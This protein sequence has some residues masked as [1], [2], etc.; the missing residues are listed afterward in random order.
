Q[1]VYRQEP[2]GDPK[3]IT[4]APPTPASLRHADGR[5]TPDGR[6][7]IC[8]RER[9]EQGREAINEIIA[10]PALPADGYSEPKIILS[11]YDFYSF[12]RTRPD[13]RRLAWTCWRHPQMPWDGSELWVGDLNADG[14]VSNTRRVAGSNSESIFQPA[15]NADGILFFISDATGWWNLYAEQNGKV[16]PVFQIEAEVGVPQWLFG[17]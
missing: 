5:V 17:Y 13:G 16:A 1:R 9:H 7:I 14:T 11:G 4:A 2:G 8:V 12:P 10:L 15:W 6:T 3:P